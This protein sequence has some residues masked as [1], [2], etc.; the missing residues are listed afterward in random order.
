MKV[1]SSALAIL[2]CAAAVAAQGIQI[3]EPADGAT[4]KAGHP[5]VVEVVRPVCV[6]HFFRTVLHA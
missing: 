1:F 2:L 5:L 3:G 4:V 6:M